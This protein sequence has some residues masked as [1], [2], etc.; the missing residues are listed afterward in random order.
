MTAPFISPAPWTVNA[1]GGARTIV[2]RDRS[3]V[4]VVMGCDS[5]APFDVGNG[6]LMA[7][8]PDLLRALTKANATLTRF[9]ESG[10][11]LDPF[12][13]TEIDEALAKAVAP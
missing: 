11:V 2:A 7:A 13:C 8:A 6:A 4:A 9:A 12:E 10:F 5:A 3:V 1:S